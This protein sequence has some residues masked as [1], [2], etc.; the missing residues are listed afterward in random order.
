MKKIALVG[1]YGFDN[2]GD[3]AIL[4]AIIASLKEYEA[5][6]EITVLSANPDK[7]AK[8]Y[9]VKAINRFQ[10]NAVIET[11]RDVDLFLVGG[12]SL[13]Q[14][15]TSQKSIL[16]YLG[17]IYLAQRI[18]VPVIFYAQGV[19]PIIRRLSRFLIPRV[20]NNLNAI[21]VRDQQ[22]KELLLGLGV[23]EEVRVTADPV[24]TLPLPSDNEIKR[25][26]D[27]ENLESNKE[28]IG[29]SVRHWQDNH[30]LATLATA[31]DQINEELGMQILFLPLHHPEDLAASQKVMAQMETAKADKQV[32]AGNYHPQQIVGLFKEVDLLIGVRL[33]SLIFAAINHTP[34]VGISYDPKVDSFLARL[35]LKA[36]GKTDDLD[37]SNLHKRV[38]K[39]WKKREQLEQHLKVRVD[40]LEQLAKENTEIAWRLLTNRSD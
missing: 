39:A 2:A 30:Y 33:H 17:L 36:A 29:V 6:L 8:E 20:L 32:L 35:G 15:V 27:N 13:L 21:T 25:I 7:T 22:S 23:K 38:L 1:Y 4:A 11:L 40:E 5:N 28:V 34:L 12:G 3:E 16:Y 19:G 37:A 31:L 24:F 26:I 18:A 9:G 10:L 14:D